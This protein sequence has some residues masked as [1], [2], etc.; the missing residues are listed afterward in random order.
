VIP[1][2]NLTSDSV[3]TLYRTPIIFAHRASDFAS[4]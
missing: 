2:T 4:A 3:L 1:G